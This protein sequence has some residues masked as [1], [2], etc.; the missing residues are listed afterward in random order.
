MV[1]YK[2]L[3]IDDEKEI[4]DLIGF[5]LRYE[6]EV[7][8]ASS[9]KEAIE[10]IDN[11]ENLAA[12]LTDH[13]MD[14]LTGTEIL[15]YLHK[16]KPEIGR[17]LITGFPD[18]QVIKEAINKGHIHRFITKPWE[19]EELREIIA[20]EVRRHDALVRQKQLMEDLVIKN[21]E[22]TKVYE[23]VMFQK[24][25]LEDLNREYKEQSQIAIELS[26]KFA[27][28]HLE[29]LDAQE[30][31]EKKNRELE[32]A[33]SKLEVLSVTDGL[34]GFFNHKYLNSILDQEIG[35]AKRYNLDLSCMMVD[36]DN[37][38]GVND[39]FGHLFGDFVLKTSSAIIKKNIRE[40]DLPARYGG[41]EFFIILPHTD[42]KKAY[43]LATRIREDIQSYPYVPAKDKKLEQKA[44]IGL[45]N[46]EKNE[47]DT[48]TKLIERVDLALYEAKGMGKNTTVIYSLDSKKS[49][50]KI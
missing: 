46:L 26:E 12:V 43:S 35:R 31:I 9:G 27:K 18:L 41:D 5:V 36:L 7:I 38:K 20:E 17:I 22:L 29:L 23:E 28:A 24:R 14:G 13:W 39:N 50:N 21:E 8:I 30:M 16:N 6:Y 4:R 47:E 48:K 19:V 15:A 1:K 44:S 40:T 32:Q 11:G 37:F 34:T 25:R 45:A 10:I 33:N 2:I 42:I 3:V 49:I